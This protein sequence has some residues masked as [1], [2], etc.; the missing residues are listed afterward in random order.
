MNE[1]LNE[2]LMLQRLKTCA[3]PFLYRGIG[4][5]P[6]TPDSRSGALRIDNDRVENEKSNFAG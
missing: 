3:A 2:Y 6:L 4:F 5:L 1:T